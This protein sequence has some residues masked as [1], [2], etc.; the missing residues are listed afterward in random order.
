V[1]TSVSYATADGTGKAG[2]DYTSTSGTVTFQPGETV[3]VVSIPVL[4]DRRSEPSE[5]FTVTLSSPTGGVALGSPRTTT[6]TINDDDMGKWKPKHVKTKVVIIVRDLKWNTL[7]KRG[8][9][10]V[11]MCNQ[12][13]SVSATLKLGSR[14]IG[15]VKTRLTKAGYTSTYVKLSK[16]GK[17]VVKPFKATRR[18]TVAATATADGGRHSTAAS[19]RATR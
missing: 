1:T 15:T 13:C 5:A 8:V 17:R 7:R 18:L 19:F 9:K 12:K 10:V 16:S 3:K 14:P 2:E 6:V 4:D 11:V